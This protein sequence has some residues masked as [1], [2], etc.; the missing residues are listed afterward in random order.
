MHVPCEGTVGSGASVPCIAHR[1]APSEADPAAVEHPPAAIPPEARA[2]EAADA[3]AA[4]MEIAVPLE[5]GGHDAIRPAWGS[6]W[7][8]TETGSCMMATPCAPPPA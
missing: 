6:G 8:K 4:S 3:K 2:G 7:A 1:D 5:G